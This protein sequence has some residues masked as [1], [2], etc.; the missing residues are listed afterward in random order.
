MSIAPEEVEKKRALITRNLSEVLG[1]ASMLKILSERDLKLYWGTA[2]TGRPHIGYFVPMSKLADFLQAGCHVTVLFADLH[3]YLDNMKAPWELLA[4]RTSYYEFV[5]KA[6]LQSIGVPIDRLSFVRGSDYQLGR[7][8]ILQVF[9][10]STMVT[11]HDAKKAGSEVVKQVEHPLL[12]GLIYPG[13]QALDEEFLGVDAQF[14]GVDQRKIFTFAEKYM[15][16]LGFRKR[17]HLMN[18]MVPG[19]NGSKMSSSE[20]DSKIDLLDDAATVRA[21]IRKAFCEE[22]NIERNGILPFAKYVLFP[23]FQYKGIAAFEIEREDRHGGSVSYPTYEQ[24]EAA[25]AAKEIF[26][27]DLKNAA[28]KYISLLIDPIRQAFMADAELQRITLA[29]YPHDAIDGL[30]AKMD[31]TNL[32][33]KDQ[34]AADFSLFDVRVGKILSASRHP[35]AENL[36]VE[37]VDL[38][39]GS[40]RTI[41][42]GL[43]KW[44]PLEELTGRSVLVLANLKPASMRGVTSHGMLLAASSETAVELVTPPEECLPGE[45]VTVATFT[46]PGTPVE[47]DIRKKHAAQFD[48]IAKDLRVS[49]MSIAEFRQLPLMTENG[50]CCVASLTN[51]LIR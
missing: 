49:A 21:K 24:L 51:C 42:S 14:G 31:E 36:Y 38:G 13:M 30:T 41:V 37:Q 26:P 33:S 39:E 8:Y 19:L 46:P 18:P 34:Q 10:M 7:E 3:A 47:L 45:R 5:I 12:A 11:E 27:L 50:P 25:F 44:I 15:P 23:V 29:A 35:D 4:L 1:E 9:R 48:S 6:M 17:V 40:P 28:A 16:A 20:A 43:A 2:T 22:G 32:T